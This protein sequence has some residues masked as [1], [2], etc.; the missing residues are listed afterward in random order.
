MSLAKGLEFRAV[1]VIACDEDLLPL[2]ERLALAA[3]E[4]ELREIYE[5][6]RHLLYVAS[7]R[8]RERLH[9]SGVTSV[10]EF[11]SELEA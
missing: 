6:E 1:A 9:V 2:S 3:S 4:P 8:A 10:S 7:T 5:T 11:L